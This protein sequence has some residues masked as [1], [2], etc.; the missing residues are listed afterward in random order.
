M[1]DARVYGAHFA[2]PA[3][4]DVAADR[5]LCKS[6]WS[7]RRQHGLSH[8]AVV[9]A[10]G[11]EVLRT[12]CGESGMQNKPAASLLGQALLF[13]DARAVDLHFEVS[14]ESKMVAGASGGTSLLPWLCWARVGFFRA[15][16]CRRWDLSPT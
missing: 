10:S 16:L 9:V 7:S 2:E 11:A 1:Q 15:W 6:H 4:A 14:R 5:F 8:H 3:G 12:Q 13:E